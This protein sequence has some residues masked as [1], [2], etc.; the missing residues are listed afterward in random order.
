MSQPTTKVEIGFDLTDSGT[1]PFFRLDDPI[2][3]VLDNTSFVLGG[4]LFYDVTNFV[5][6]VSITRKINQLEKNGTQQN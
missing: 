2:Q 4:E 3:G 1:G 6:S 5:T